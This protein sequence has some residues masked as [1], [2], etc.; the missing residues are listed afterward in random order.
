[1]GSMNFG[2]SDTTNMSR[3][4]GR[5]KER[6][7]TSLDA[8][9]SLEQLLQ[10]IGVDISQ[11]QLQALLGSQDFNQFLTGQAREGFSAESLAESE[12]RANQAGQITDQE[13]GF[14]QDAASLGFQQ[15]SSDIDRST[16][17]GL[18]QLRQEL[19]PGRGL[20]SSDTPILDRGGQIV[21]AG[22]HQKGQLS[23]GLQGQAAQARLAF[24]LQRQAFQEQLRNRAFQNRLAL[25]G[26]ASQFGLG[27]AGL[28]NPAGF[29]SNFLN[30]RIAG[31]DTITRR[32]GISDFHGKSHTDNISY[33]G[34]GGGGGGG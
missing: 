21:G 15:G 1:M 28:F 4:R 14:I 33:G 23:L 34:G 20:R 12:A 11:T 6:A 25:S 29:Q 17:L 31:K 9:G 22:I 3:T 2:S 27:I 30:E 19:A 5:S 13:A 8:A 16:T 7:N 32:S 18:Q 24:P 10:Q 26:Q